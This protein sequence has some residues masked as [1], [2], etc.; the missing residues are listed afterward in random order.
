MPSAAARS[1][2]LQHVRA[3]ARSHWKNLLW[4]RLGAGLVL[5]SGVVVEL[6]SDAE[7]A[8]FAEIFV[9][10]Q[11][12]DAIVR[13]FAADTDP[14]RVIDLGA[15]VGFFTLRVQH[16]ARQLVPGRPVHILAVEGVKRTADELRR[17]CGG[18][19]VTPNVEVSVCHGL[20]GRRSGRAFIYDS[21][22]AHQNHVVAD[23][24]ARSN[25]PVRNAFAVESDYLD[26][27]QLTPAEAPIDLV[28]CD[29]EGSELAFIETYPDLL[30]RTRTLVI[31][32]HPRLCDPQACLARLADLG[33]RQETV[34]FEGPTVSLLL[35]TRPS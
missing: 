9:E 21:T 23:G 2:P 32:L 29:I 19:N 1:S 10:R 11:Y 8:I 18:R 5:E 6:K 7:W 3:L 13:A 14:V 4:R 20:V 16:L 27:E 17:R 26:I 22:Q 34:I 24:G 12:D 33:F 15:N 28:K 31:E 25:L 35:M 30:R